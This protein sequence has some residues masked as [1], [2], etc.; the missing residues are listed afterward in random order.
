MADRVTV[1]VQM[2]AETCIL[3]HGVGTIYVP[4]WG[5]PETGWLSIECNHNLVKMGMVDDDPRSSV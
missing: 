4:W 2:T 3:C 1:P 5:V